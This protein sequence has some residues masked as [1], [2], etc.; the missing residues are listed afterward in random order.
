[1][2]QILLYITLGAALVSAGCSTGPRRGSPAPVVRTQPAPVTSV[3]GAAE[4]AVDSESIAYPA[5]ESSG[6]DIMPELLPYSISR[7]KPAEV[8]VYPSQE[9]PASARTNNG[10]VLALLS[11]A[12]RQQQ[13]GDIPG[14]AATLERALRI[15]PRN[16]R[17]W[18]RLAAL[19]LDQKSYR[20]A[21]GL[22]DKSN[23]LAPE[24]AD[25]KRAN[26]RLI[27]RARSALGDA[28]GAQEAWQM[29]R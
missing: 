18:H 9:P 29:A 17:L 3:K 12:G 24:D 13:G 7:P 28:T 11:N 8:T 14:A 22:A 21:A 27:A 25:L 2:R 23:S 10:A 19:R 1:M 15:E 5:R 6:A 20:M 16:A 26:W 4:I